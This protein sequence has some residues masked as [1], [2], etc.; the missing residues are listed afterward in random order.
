MVNP[1]EKL[2]CIGSALLPFGG[3]AVGA[4]LYGLEGA[5]LGLAGGTMMA[6]SLAVVNRVSRMELR[7]PGQIYP[8][9]P[10]SNFV[11]KWR[12][13]LVEKIAPL[14]SEQERIS[15]AINNYETEK[16]GKIAEAES[17]FNHY[18]KS[19]Q[20][21]K[22]IHLLNHPKWH[23]R[24]YHTHALLNRQI[25]PIKKQIDDLQKEIDDNKEN[26]EA[27]QRAIDSLVSSYERLLFVV[28]KLAL[29]QVEL[30]DVL[31]FDN[32]SQVKP[33]LEEI[34]QLQ[35]IFTT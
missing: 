27:L 33:L 13:K 18:N 31:D 24:N 8:L 4:Y 7:F 10:E 20:P 14:Q 5:G 3:A 35:A 16:K 1:R 17:I 30:G 23:W 12:P 2:G 22:K 26:I 28:A 32:H 19:S 6:V 21:T 29:K 11:Q 25:A 15:N 34:T 9:E